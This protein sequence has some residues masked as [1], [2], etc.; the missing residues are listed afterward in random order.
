MQAA[1]VDESDIWLWWRVGNLA[2][3]VVNLKLARFAFEKVNK[4]FNLKYIF[5]GSESND[6][7]FIYKTLL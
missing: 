1:V 4:S 3:D 7:T 6:K 2:M 5:L